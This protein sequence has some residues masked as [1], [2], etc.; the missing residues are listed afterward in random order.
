MFEPLVT[1]TLIK[2]LEDTFPSNPLR[3]MTHRELD[4]MIGQQEVVAYL[5]MLLDEQKT[6]DVN[7]EVS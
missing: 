1:E 5:K 6:A 3:S 4:V 7:L 2:K